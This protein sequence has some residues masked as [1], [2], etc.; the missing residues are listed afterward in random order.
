MRSHFM[1]VCAVLAQNSDLVKTKAGEKG[2]DDE[3][4]PLSRV[5]LPASGYY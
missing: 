3:D 4:Y 5:I 2:D 1:L